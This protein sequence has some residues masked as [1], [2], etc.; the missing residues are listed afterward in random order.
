[1]SDDVTARADAKLEAAL[2][3]SG[4]RD[5]R[6]F[7]RERLRELKQA[8][9]S[10]YDEAVEYYKTVL[11][12]SVADGDGHPLDAWTEYGRKLA[13]SVAPGRTVAIDG[14]GRA[15]PFERPDRSALILHLPDAKG[16]RALLVG[17]PDELTPAQRAS[18]DVL[19][20]GKQRLPA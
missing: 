20:A 17:L 19:V 13:T 11:L 14:T 16:S 6:D 10:A 12:P 15:R 8:D 2:A 18:Y 3:A 5:P 9:A 7:Y 1:M 4:A